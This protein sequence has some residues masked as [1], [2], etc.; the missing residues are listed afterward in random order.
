MLKFTALR[1]KQVG[2]RRA[3]MARFQNLATRDAS[4]S[5]VKALKRPW[6]MISAAVK[7]PQQMIGGLEHSDSSGKHKKHGFS[8]DHQEQ[9]ET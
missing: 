5:A 2:A 7:R 4:N 9:C 1:L 8:N 6:Q 3:T